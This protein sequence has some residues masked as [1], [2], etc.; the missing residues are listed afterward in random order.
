MADGASGNATHEA[1]VFTKLTQD[2][3]IIPRY[4]CK[5]ADLMF[6]RNSRMLRVGC[7]L[8]DGM[9]RKLLPHHLWSLELNS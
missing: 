2:E 1:T 8:G 6:K 5:E 7:C 4:A 9:L 3:S